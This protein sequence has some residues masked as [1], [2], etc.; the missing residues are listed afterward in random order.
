MDKIKKNILILVFLIFI[1]IIFV[2]LFLLLKNVKK[3]SMPSDKINN[4]TDYRSELIK[5]PE[6]KHISDTSIEEALLKR[7]SIRDYKD[8]P[9]TLREVSQLLWAVQGV[10]NEEGLRTAPSAGAL[11]PLEI[12]AVFTNIEGIASGVYKYKPQKHELEM[13]LEGDKR[14]ELYNAALNQSAIQDAPLAIVFSAVYERTTKKYGEKGKRY[15]HMEAGHAAQ[16]IYLQAVSLNLGTVTIGA[17]DE[18]EVKRI[19]NISDDENLLYIMP[20]GRK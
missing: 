2:V 10:T 20:V 16:N 4:Q 7:R 13:I 1:I 18:E 9:L 5:L 8:E 12:Y 11:Y 19:L 14:I 17:F 15:V 3:I 6:P